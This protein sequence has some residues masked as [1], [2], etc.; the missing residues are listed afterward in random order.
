[1]VIKLGK[2]IIEF[3]RVE[4][5]LIDL[6]FK[7]ENESLKLLTVFASYMGTVVL[8]PYLLLEPGTKIAYKS[9]KESLKILLQSLRDK[10]A[11]PDYLFSFTVLKSFQIQAIY[12]LFCVRWPLCIL[13]TKGAVEH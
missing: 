9:R 8:L 2:E 7:S 6:S 1:M 10:L 5:V 12:K 4:Q 11:N 13:N 3:L